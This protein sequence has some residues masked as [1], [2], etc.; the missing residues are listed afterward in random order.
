MIQSENDKNLLTD[1]K[2]I[3]DIFLTEIFCG[4]IMDNLSC[5]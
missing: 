2:R 5:C 1:S 3:N 4:M